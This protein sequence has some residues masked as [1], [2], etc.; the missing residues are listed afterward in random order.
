LD[1]TIRDFSP[2]YG[3][4]RAEGAAD[5][6]VTIRRALAHDAGAGAACHI[7]CWREAYA[8]IVEPKVLAERTSDLAERT[9][10]WRQMITDPRPRW[11]AVTAGGEVVGFSAAGPGRDDDIDI[12]LELY[13]IYVRAAHQGTGIADRLIETALG[14]AAAYLWV[15]EANPR[16][17]AFYT[18][19]R[20]APEGARKMEPLFERPEIRMARD[21]IVTTA[22]S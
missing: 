8:T 10:R 9:E 16:A 2:P 13:A 6:T 7:A 20:F 15:F 5:V 12:G 4:A 1:P 11:I 14:P 17:R 21:Q 18:R 3:R 19:H 22:G